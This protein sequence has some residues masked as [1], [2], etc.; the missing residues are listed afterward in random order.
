MCIGGSGSIGTSS[1]RRRRCSTSAAPLQTLHQRGGQGDQ[2]GIRI[3]VV[4]GTIGRRRDR[5]GRGL[6]FRFRLCFRYRRLALAVIAVDA[7]V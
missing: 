2:C 3:V 4:V 6:E 7:V 1:R 5:R